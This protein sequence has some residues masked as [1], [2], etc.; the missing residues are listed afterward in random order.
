MAIQSEDAQAVLAVP[1]TTGYARYSTEAADW[2]V[3][4]CLRELLA[5]AGLS[6]DSI[7]GLAVSSFTLAPDPVASLSRS[8]GLSLRWLESVPFGGASGVIALRRAA[9][10]VEAGDAE[11]VACIGADANPRGGF[12]GLASRFSR[13]AIDAVYPYGAAGPNMPFAHLTQR[14]MD[15]TGATRVDFGRLCVSQRANAS[16]VAHALLRDPISLE[17]YLEARPIAEPLHKLDVVMPCAGAE[18]FLVMPRRRAL[19]L[20][21]PYA[22]IRSVVER[23]NAYADDE[24]ILRGGWAQECSRLYREAGVG[25]GDI[26]VLA[27]YDDYP[28]VVFL[29]LEGLGFCPPRAAAAFIQSHDLSFGGDFPHNT[30][31]GQLGCGQAGAAGGYLGLV[32]VL[33]QVTAQAGANQVRAARIGLASGYGMAV[34]DRCLATGAAIIEGVTP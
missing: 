17:A 29:Q 30:S 12:A 11:V 5:G 24:A 25:C 10:A 19:R 21:V 27:T 32:E 15:A 33:R 14:Y 4:Q 23:H 18:G 22:R 20:G 28:A 16:A 31:G 3:A 7:D 8:L 26:D 2:Y 1:V 9:R 34:Y 6:K 13:A